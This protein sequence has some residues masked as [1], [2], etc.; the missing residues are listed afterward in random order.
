[1]AERDNGETQTRQRVRVLQE[2]F[3]E[4]LPNRIKQIG[5]DWR[6][7]LEED[8][9][10]AA[11]QSLQMKVRSLA[12]SSGSFG[13]ASLGDAAR[14]LELLLKGVV[15]RPEALT[16]EQAA[17]IE[18]GVTDLKRACLEFA[19]AGVVEVLD[20]SAL[21]LA[22]DHERASR[23]IFLIT[24]DG[25]L[26][27]D[28][29]FEIG[30]FGFLVRRIPDLEELERHLDQTRPAAII[31]DA[32]PFEERMVEAARVNALRQ[33]RDGSIPVFVLASRTDFESRLEAVR[34][35]GDAYLVRPLEARKLIDKLEV[36]LQGPLSEPYRVLIVEEDYSASLDYSLTLQGAGMTTTLVHDP[37]KLWESLVEARP[38]LIMISLSLAGI[39]G[40][41]LAAV[42]R[43]QD[44][45]MEIPIILLSAES[46]LGGQI[47][48]MRVEA[49]DVLVTPISS[50]VLISSVGNHVQRARALKRFV[51][52]DSLTGLLSHTSFLT[53]LVLE[54]DRA[55]ASNSQLAF[56][57]IDI[58]HLHAINETYGHLSGDSALTNLAGLLKQRMR[59]SDV[60]S[61]Y[62]GDE[63]AVVMP[64]TSGHNAVKVL[65]GICGLYAEIRE[66]S[67]S[68]VY[69]PTFSC[70][71]AALPGYED[72][73]A[74]RQAALD[75]L[76]SARRQGRN[77]V[78]L[79]ET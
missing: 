76:D 53:K 39:S 65:D 49:D 46:G 78:V 75:A 14:R 26:A 66:Y 3:A 41:H 20:A 4:Q 2:A 11:L 43:Q 13:F 16:P 52:T 71:V 69:F 22:I 23:V 44:A 56:A 34:S 58:D 10:G 27:A 25:Q 51:S 70:G 79:V 30:C 18:Q 32:E 61:R 64:A 28:L 9:S 35:G 33:K 55:L 68:A 50:D 77:R 8:R 37:M 63:I 54:V 21:D 48:A 57:V 19:G 31:L 15:V 72:C 60:L 24:G 40:F 62:G 74:L 73:S 47:E 7:L 42:I 59:R 6:S 1:M 17:R 29:G 12:S 67:A 36:Q 45:Y 5:K 38:D